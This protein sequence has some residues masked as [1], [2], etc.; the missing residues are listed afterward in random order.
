MSSFSPPNN[1]LLSTA[2]FQNTIF[3]VR[4]GNSEAN[5]AKVISSNPDVATKIHGLSPL[6]VSQAQASVL[7]FASDS[8][9]Q[10]LFSCGVV[11]V[12]SDFTR[13]R[14]TASI[15]ALEFERLDVPL[16]DD[17]V[18]LD[19]RLRERFFGDFD[20]GSDENYHKVWEQDAISADHTSFNVESVTSVVRRT[21]ELVAELNERH[22]GK[23]ILLFAHGDVLQILQTAVEKIDG[24]M[25]RQLPH[26]NTA[27]F[28][29]LCLPSSEVAPDANAESNNKS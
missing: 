26:L 13:A 23:T 1:N 14:E 2:K 9:R 12:S 28:R 7:N 22:V 6:G 15:F 21:T 20:A 17:G 5:Q 25:H 19:V 18:A 3:V 8:S 10:L 27:D 4:H 16:V 11:L 29:Q 24:S